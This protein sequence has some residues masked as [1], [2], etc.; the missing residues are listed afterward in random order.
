[1]RGDQAAASSAVNK[2]LDA[3]LYGMLGMGLADAQ[4]K[5]FESKLAAYGWSLP[6][7]RFAE[8]G[9]TWTLARK[10][11]VWNTDEGRAVDNTDC[12][13]KSGWKICTSACNLLAML[14]GEGKTGMNGARKQADVKNGEKLRELLEA[15][16]DAFE[17]N[18]KAE[19]G[20]DAK[21]LFA[22][23]TEWLVKMRDE[24]DEEDAAV[25]NA[26]IVRAKKK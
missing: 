17:T 3:M 2:A 5:A 8:K 21:I 23:R 25:F 6:P 19:L 7:L 12:V 11:L 13:W 4:V 26:L 14:K 15:E 9:Q 24:A 20:A 16:A 10:T 22:A 18:V 1:M